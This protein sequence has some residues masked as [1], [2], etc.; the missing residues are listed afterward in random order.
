MGKTLAQMLETLPADEREAIKARTRELIAE[1]LT[2]RDL[3]KAMDK[4]QVAVA[5]K[6][7]IGQDS[8]SRLEKRS[9]LMLSTLRGYIEAM[10]GALELVA[11]F[12]N[13]PPVRL[14]GLAELKGKK[15]G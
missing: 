2:L 8:V 5:K 15:D 12:P 14:A 6:L 10:D 7:H 13:R 4:T 9:D 3:R 11:R 1:E